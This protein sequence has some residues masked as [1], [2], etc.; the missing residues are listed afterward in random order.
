MV[1]PEPAPVPRQAAAVPPLLTAI[2]TSVVL[3][4]VVYFAVQ[5]LFQSPGS[6]LALVCLVL[7]GLT[8]GNT[9]RRSGLRSLPALLLLAAAVL[10]GGLAFVFRP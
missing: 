7:M 2:P 3:G 8:V 4:V 1:R 5:V 10:G 6:I 9:V